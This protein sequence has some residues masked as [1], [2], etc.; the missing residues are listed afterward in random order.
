MDTRCG[1][2]RIVTILMVA[3]AVIE[4]SRRLTFNDID[5]GVT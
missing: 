2:Q 4:I 3:D 1:L 5:V